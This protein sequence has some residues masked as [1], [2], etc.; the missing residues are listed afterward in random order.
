MLAWTKK[1]PRHATSGPALP[2]RLARRARSAPQE[3]GADASTRRRNRASEGTMLR[4]AQVRA[5]ICAGLY[6][7]IACVEARAGFN[8]TQP[9]GQHQVGGL[10]G[11]SGASPGGSS[12][13]CGCRNTHASGLAFCTLPCE[14]RACE[15]LGVL[16][17]AL[18]EARM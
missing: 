6:P 17:P 11:P 10:R 7:N 3:A 13:L 12:R 9:G 8:P 5:V 4:G 15:R 16:H 18:R 1:Y 14:R 2:W